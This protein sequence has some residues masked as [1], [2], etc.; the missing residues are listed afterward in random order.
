MM[1]KQS[2]FFASRTDKI[3]AIAKVDHSSGLTG[4][5]A[6]EAIKVIVSR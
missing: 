6:A 5:A 2:E 4:A 3:R 1:A